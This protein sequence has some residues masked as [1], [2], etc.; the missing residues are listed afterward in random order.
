[1]TPGRSPTCQSDL[2]VGPRSADTSVR[3]APS[4]R[5]HADGG[6]ALYCTATVIVWLLLL[7]APIVTT[8]GWFPEAA[9]AGTNAL[10]WITP[11]TSVGASPAYSICA[12]W[13][14]IVT[15]TGVATGFENGGAPRVS[16]AVSTGSACRPSPVAKISMSR[17]LEAGLLAPLTL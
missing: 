15:V 14:P 16:E 13:P 9:P 5:T 1:M 7:L 11:A 8:T 12:G 6:A 3:A 4:R 10:I 17:R 2:V